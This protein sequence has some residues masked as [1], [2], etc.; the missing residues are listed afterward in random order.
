MYTQINILKHIIMYYINYVKMYDIKY[1]IYYMYIYKFIKCNKI[2]IKPNNKWNLLFIFKRNI[3]M[4]YYA[5][6]N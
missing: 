3:A 6:I 1:I 2:N 5:I 4:Q